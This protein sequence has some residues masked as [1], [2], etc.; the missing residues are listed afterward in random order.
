MN[1]ADILILLVVVVSIVISLVR[2]FVREVLSLVAWVAAFWVAAAF[3]APV[4]VLLEP[5]IDIATLRMVIA[6]IAAMIVTLIAAGLV[7]L[8][9]AKLISHTGLSGTDRMLGALFGAA[10]GAAIV[11]IAVLLAG[12]TPLP[13][14]PWWAQSRAIA[15]FENAAIY[16]L[17]WLPPDLAKNFSF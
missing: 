13:A 1:W 16:V 15:P 9:I 14:Q 11:G 5:Y 4:S 8:V 6:F 2:G 12:L 7:N 3:A 17:R 10:R